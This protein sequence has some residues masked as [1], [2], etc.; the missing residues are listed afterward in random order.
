MGKGRGEKRMEEEA[1][2]GGGNKEVREVAAVLFAG[3]ALMDVGFK[4][5]FWG[6]LGLKAT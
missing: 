1:S 3:D 6:G 5:L 4:T 2:Y